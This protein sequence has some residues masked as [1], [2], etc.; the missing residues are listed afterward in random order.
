MGKLNPEI[1]DMIETMIKNNKESNKYNFDDSK[2]NIVLNN[3]EFGK[4]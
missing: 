2:P 1:L 4:Y 3:S